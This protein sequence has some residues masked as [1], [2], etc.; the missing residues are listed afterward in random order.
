LLFS[1]SQSRVVVSAKPQ[2]V[3]SVLAAAGRW[4]VP[5]ARIGET[6]GDRLSIEID[7]EVIVDAGLDAVRSAWSEGLTRELERAPCVSN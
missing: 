7:G 6:G 4:G 1:E 3:A 2:D 5:A